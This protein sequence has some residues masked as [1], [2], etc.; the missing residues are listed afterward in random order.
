MYNLYLSTR[1]I[2]ELVASGELQ[3]IGKQADSLR[4]E[5]SKVDPERVEMDCYV[6][7]DE[8]ID[9]INQSR[10]LWDSLTEEDKKDI[11]EVDGRKYIKKI[12]LANHQE[13]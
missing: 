11:I 10:K 1:G 3:E 12:W 13:G 8:Q 7:S 9:R 2:E 5:I 4:T 6:L